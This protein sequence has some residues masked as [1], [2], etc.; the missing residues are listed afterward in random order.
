V[1]FAVGRASRS[2]Q[3]RPCRPGPGEVATT[4]QDR[5][6]TIFRRALERDNPEEGSTEGLRLGA[7]HALTSPTRRRPQNARAGQQR[8]YGSKQREN[9]PEPSSSLPTLRGCSALS[10]RRT[11][12][13][14]SGGCSRRSPA[15]RQRTSHPRP[16]RESMRRPKC[17]LFAGVVRRWPARTSASVRGRARRE[18]TR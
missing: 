16:R 5:P 14:L 12:L 3:K 10:F 8:D 11:L 18:G 15:A 7:S 9:S 2:A 13:G 17:S 6:R 1:I 4:S